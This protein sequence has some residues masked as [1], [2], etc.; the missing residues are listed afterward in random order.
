MK[1]CGEPRGLSTRD[2]FRVAFDAGDFPRGVW[3]RQTGMTVGA[4]AHLLIV[5]VIN[6][7][8]LAVANRTVGYGGTWIGFSTVV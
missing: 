7:L 1:R 8:H 3:H 6:D 2:P 4:D 5:P